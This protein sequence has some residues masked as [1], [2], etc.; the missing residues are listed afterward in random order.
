MIEE[1]CFC[2]SFSLT[3]DT[4]LPRHYNPSITIIAVKATYFADEAV[5]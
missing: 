1:T 2:G 4:F 5:T 3:V